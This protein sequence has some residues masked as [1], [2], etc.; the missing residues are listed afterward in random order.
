MNPILSAQY[1]RLL[2][3]RL[4]KVWE[5][6]FSELTQMIPQI[7]NVMSSDSAWEEF[8]GVSSFPDT[9]EFSGQLEY[10]GLNPE[11]LFRVE[12][13]EFAMGVQIE[14]KFHDDKKYNVMD[15]MVGGL[16]ESLIRTQEKYSVEMFANG[17]S[18]AY[19]FGYSEEGVALLGSH[20]TKSGVPTT[21]G[22]S[23]TGT[24][25]LS[26]TNIAATRLLMRRFKGSI[27]QRI[28]IDPDTIIVP[29][30]LYDTACEIVGY[31]P[32]SGANS[33]RDPDS[34]HYGR[35]N[36]NY[37]RFKVIPWMRLDDYSTKSW[38]M[39][40][41]RQMKKHL[42]WLNRVSAEYK[43]T[44]DFEN[45]MTKH[46]GYSRWGAGFDEWRWGYGNQVT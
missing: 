27:G 37:K 19:T 21:T 46:S 36:A 11:Y 45:F 33:D 30:S 41:S 42:Y 2:D 6:P 38:Y 32:R 1:I 13:K 29:D 17:W 28:E 26:K 43:M 24:L 10:F 39:A 20:T 4:K 3:K 14:R 18:N 40:D 9:P 31:D 34:A 8:Y 44:V 12:P 15:N 16:S 35:I 7:F 5:R 23:N 25:A 22:F